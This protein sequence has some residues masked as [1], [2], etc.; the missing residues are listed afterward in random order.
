M[1]G[2]GF[3]L[4]PYIFQVKK[5]KKYEDL[6][7]YKDAKSI[8]RQDNKLAPIGYIFAALFFLLIGLILYLIIKF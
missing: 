1:V 6:I 5:A 7:A 2:Y 4:V 3:Q 8:K